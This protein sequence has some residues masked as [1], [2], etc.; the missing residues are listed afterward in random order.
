MSRRPMIA[1]TVVLLG[2]A[3]GLASG[4]EEVTKRMDFERMIDQPKLSA[5][6]R[7]PW[8]AV[9]RAVRRPVDGTVPRERELT[10]VSLDQTTIPIPVDD[11]L[12]RRGR[13]YYER[14]C[15]TC[16]GMV[17]L[18]NPGV[19]PHMTLRPPPS[20][21]EPRIREQAPGRLYATIT[22]G[23]GLMPGYAR[24]LEGYDRWAVIAYLQVL[25]I[26]Q[27]VRLT[28]LPPPL[29]EQARTELEP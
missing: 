26:S 11:R 2:L 12:L 5:F 10:T 19:V 14:L 3:S 1:A 17:G 23:Y 25:W 24:W 6:E 7:V 20:L 15:A 4:C 28:D 18:G 13:V 8:P 22:E 21:L 27:G 16:H 29:A 9:R